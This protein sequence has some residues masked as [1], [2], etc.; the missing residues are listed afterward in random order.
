M[1]SRVIAPATIRPALVMCI[2]V[3]GCAS[4]AVA[5]E[6]DGLDL[7][8]GFKATVVHEGI[9]LA[10][11]LAVR[12]NGDVYVITRA[13]R[14]GRPDPGPYR[15]IVALRDT[16][17]DGQADE[18]RNFS[19]IQGTGIA[20][21]GDVLY[22]ADDVTVY[23]FRFDGDELVPS[24]GP[25]VIAEGFVPERQHAAKSLALDG[26]G[27]VYVNVGAPSNSCQEDD[28]T[29]GSRGHSPCPLLQRYGG[30]WK[31]DADRLGQDQQADGER[32]AS[33]LRNAVALAWN[34][35]VGALYVV[36]H[37]RDQLDFLFPELFDA[38]YNAERVA[39]EMHRI[40]PGREYGWPYTYY[41]PID[42]RRLVA[43]EY[44]GDGNKEPP[45]DRYPEPV[46]AFPAH[47][48]PNDLVFYDGDQFPE[49]YR[50][51]AFIAFHGSWNRA[52]LPQAGFNVSFAPLGADGAAAGEWSVFADGFAGG[53]I[54][55]PT[56]AKAR[57]MGLAVSPDGSL[58][59]ADSVRG[60]IWRIRYDGP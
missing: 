33:G 40:E 58:Y 52:P 20:I 29:P 31:F 23:R 57:P 17:G 48:A 56:D 50:G 35:Q 43:P 13:A 26:E 14:P 60:R 1:P 28:R 27:H 37:G 55:N 25:E 22:V 44:G 12:G 34:H 53:E 6:N 54:E 8:N 3:L 10:R 2:A 19:D 59:V 5:A 38:R 24:A 7:P 32:F 42:D 9:G 51:G 15:G 39:E 45:A 36:Q 11:H 21:H 49:A 18:A 16:N 46:V 47:W 4:T 41:D 30:V